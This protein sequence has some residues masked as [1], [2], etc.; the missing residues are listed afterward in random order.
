[1]ADVNLPLTHY[2]NE[3][4]LRP[5]KSLSVLNKI[6]TDIL[7]LLEIYSL[8]TPIKNKPGPVNWHN[9]KRRY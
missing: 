8:N 3:L 5:Q 4:H 2:F 9:L 7:L 6:A 1:M